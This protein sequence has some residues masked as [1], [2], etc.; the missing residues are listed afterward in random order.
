[1]KNHTGVIRH[2]FKRLKVYEERQ[3]TAQTLTV[4][5]QVATGRWLTGRQPTEPAPQ[6][7]RV[8]PVT[9]WVPAELVLMDYGDT[10]RK[11]MKLLTGV[12]LATT[13]KG[14]K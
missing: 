8:A 4:G 12:Q 2:R 9:F 10:E 1:M 7:L 6:R 11:L 14:A 13:K 5:L 3:L